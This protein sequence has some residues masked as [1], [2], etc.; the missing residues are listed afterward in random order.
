MILC[1]IYHNMT[2]VTLNNIISEHSYMD[3][4]IPYT[5]S[6]D[7]E[8]DIMRYMTTSCHNSVTFHFSSNIKWNKMM[9]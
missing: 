1:D 7:M 4:T 6:C 2:Y 8:Y 9:K 5:Q 3:T